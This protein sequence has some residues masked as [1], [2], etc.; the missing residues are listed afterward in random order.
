[1]SGLAFPKPV[2]AIAA[3]EHELD[4]RQWLREP[5]RRQ[6]AVLRHIVDHGDIIDL[7]AVCDDQGPVR[8][9]W[10]LVPLDPE[11]LDVLA[12]FEAELTDLEIEHGDR[13]LDADREPLLGAAENHHKQHGWAAGVTDARKATATTSPTKA[14]RRTTLKWRCGT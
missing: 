4:G 1:M 9:Q 13:E 3:A 10:L 6:V 12:R 11:M 8:G 7:P 2:G 5:T 14:G